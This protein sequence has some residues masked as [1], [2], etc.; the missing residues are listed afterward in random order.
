MKGSLIVW[1]L[2]ISALL[3][4]CVT[5][6]DNALPY[7]RLPEISIAS[8]VRLVASPA[9]P[10]SYLSSEPLPSGSKVQ[11]V[12]ADENLAW[13]LVLHNGRL[14]W[15]PTF[16]SATPVGALIPAIVIEPLNGDCTQYLGMT[17]S[18]QQ[19]VTS[20]KRGNATILGTI[21]RP[22]RRNRFDDASLSL[23]ITGAGRAISADYIHPPLTNSSAII[24]FAF[25]LE[26]LEPGSRISFHLTR[27]NGEDLSFQTAYFSDECQG[28]PALANSQYVD[29]LPIGV[30][31]VDLPDA[32]LQTPHP[33]TTL[34]P[35]PTV[36][37]TSNP[38][39]PGTVRPYTPTPTPT[40]VGIGG[41]Q[42]T[43]EL[44][45]Q[46]SEVDF[47]SIADEAASA[48]GYQLLFSNKTNVPL[49][50]Q[51]T[52]DDVRAVDNKGVPYGDYY[53]VSK[54]SSA[55][56]EIAPSDAIDWTQY[57]ENRF[58]L[59]PGQS[60]LDIFWL[61]KESAG[62]N[63][64]SRVDIDTD[65][66]D[67]TFPEIKY[68]G[69]TF[70]T[71]GATWRLVRSPH[72]TITPTPTKRATPARTPTPTH[73]RAPTR[74]PTATQRPTFTPT[75]KIVDPREMIVAYWNKIDRGQFPSAWND[76]SPGF[77]QRLHED[78]YEDYWQGY[79]EMN[80]CGVQT[81]DVA[82]IEQSPSSSQVVATVIYSVGSTCNPV[83]YS[84]I[85][86]LIYDPTQSAWLIDRVSFR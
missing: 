11:V 20:I 37:V 28:G 17:T 79:Q 47:R 39:S 27:T 71:F 29:R 42:G 18:P 43:N 36:F 45:I 35:P 12:G 30:L 83:V 5:S 44:D 51:F 13:L 75:A 66:I 31:K 55:Q 41:K 67:L 63:E 8:S 48:V 72:P 52:L 7:A 9:H 86:H 38:S 60:R 14:G 70:Q 1:L 32:P 81:R 10:T 24:L 65:W 54:R 21:Y 56:E 49:E 15:M 61:H 78:K 16:F 4:G 85:F 6:V 80:L 19:E 33:S 2:S 40:P 62:W 53:A 25:Y 82:T 58:I 84:F 69:F 34:T 23:E 64:K 73:T 50:V 57:T 68:R 46:L 77:R 22:Q 76:L 59:Q 74:T 26:D 3:V